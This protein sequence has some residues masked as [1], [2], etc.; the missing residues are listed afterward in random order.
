[1]A[2][3]HIPPSGVYT[4]DTTGYEQATVSRSY[5]PQS[6]RIVDTTNGRF[7]NHHI[8]SQEHEEWFSLRATSAGGVMLRRRIRVTF[9]P[10]TVDDT[11][12]FDPPLLGVPIPYRLGQTWRG[13]WKGDTYGT[14]TG[15]TVDHRTIHVAGR[16]IEVW[17]EQLEVVAHGRLTGT[18]DTTLWWA[19][20]LGLDVREDGTYDVR[21]RGVP[22][23]YHTQYTITLASTRPQ[24]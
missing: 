18:V 11:V 14:Y 15:K 23:T 7:D 22:G 8:F 20:K 4:Y 3:W 16:S 21:E 9:G 12:V 17:K 1:V 6:Q 19:P 5:P 24:Q 2:W 10:V 13:S